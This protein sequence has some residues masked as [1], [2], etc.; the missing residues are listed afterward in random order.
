MTVSLNVNGKQYTSRKRHGPPLARP[1][2]HPERVKER[3]A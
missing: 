1:A 3:L 2:A